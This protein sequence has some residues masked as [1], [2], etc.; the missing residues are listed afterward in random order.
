MAACPPRRNGGGSVSGWV[1]LGSGKAE[2]KVMAPEKLYLDDLAVGD[3]FTSGSYELSEAE[4][5]GFAMQYDPQPFHLD[6]EAARES[7]FGRL[8]AS[9]WHTAAVTMKLLVGSVPIA[10]G[11]IGGGGEINWPKPA[12]PG[13]VL[14]VVSTVT[15]ILPSRSKPDRGVVGLRSETLTRNDEVVQVLKAKVF[16]FRRPG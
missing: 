15:E 10:G 12:R 1:G 4:V 13:D 3:V 9:G 6:D 16:V 5:K 8:A 7:I 11:I 2:E 14:R